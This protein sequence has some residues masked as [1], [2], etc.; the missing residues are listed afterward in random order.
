MRPARCR[1]R[2]RLQT[3]GVASVGVDGRGRL[4]YIAQVTDTAE[5]GSYYVNERYEGRP[6]RIYRRE[7]ARFV[8]R[9]RAKYHNDGRQLTRDLGAPRS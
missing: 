9:P 4:I 8:L 1:R 7:G 5:G 3:R 2:V 6:D